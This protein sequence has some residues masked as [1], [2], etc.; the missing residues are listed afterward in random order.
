M[1]NR[2][3]LRLLALGL[4]LALLAPAAAHAETVVTDDTVGDVVKANWEQRDLSE[5]AM[6]PAPDEVS[7]DIVRT[8]VAHG[9][10]R[11]SLTV[12]FRE[13]ARVND[14]STFA[15]IRTSD[16]GAFDLGL[17]KERGS[18]ATVSLGTPQGDVDCQGLRGAIDRGADRVVFSVPTTCLGD[19]RWV[20]LGVGATGVS[21]PP[22]GQDQMNFDLF[23]DIAGR[24]TFANEPP[25]LGP[26]VHRG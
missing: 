23:A 26:R 7:T 9:T 16:R 25:V 1:T 10:R 22:E 6:V 20:R 4:P 18:R 17:D 19:P 24:P 5:P 15:R 11:L 8:V 3:G 12:R 21:W 14:Q 13:I 2:R